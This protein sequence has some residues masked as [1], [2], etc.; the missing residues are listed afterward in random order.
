MNGDWSK[1]METWAKLL[2]WHFWL[3]NRSFEFD[4]PRLSGTIYTVLEMIVV[5][6]LQ[7]K[8]LPDGELKRKLNL[9][10][11]QALDRWVI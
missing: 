3:W 9:L 1:Y 7:S 6:T 10:A 2:C 4:N 8:D 11:R 5:L